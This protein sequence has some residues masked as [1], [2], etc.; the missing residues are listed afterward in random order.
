MSRPRWL[1]VCLALF[2]TFF[3]A[4]LGVSAQAWKFSLDR[5]VSHV[6]VQK[7]GSA[8]IEYWLAFTCDKG[9]HPLD[10]I[11]IGMPNKTY[12]LGTAQAWYVPADGGAEVALARPVQSEMIST[13]IEVHLGKYTIQPGKSGTIHV[14]I[15]VKQMVYPDKDEAYASV[16][17]AP[18]Y[19]D[20][21]NVHGNTF[22]EIA[23]YF[24]VGVTNEQ[25]RYH[26]KKYDYVDK[27]NDRIVFIYQYPNAKGSETHKHGI[28]FPRQYVDTVH[29]APLVWGGS[30]SGG[31]NPFAVLENIIEGLSS[32]GCFGGFIALF[33]AMSALGS[34]QQKRRKMV[35]LPPALSVEGVGI[36][37]GLTAVEAAILLE[38]P[39]NKVL[40]MI[41]FGLLKKKAVVVLEENPLKLE[42]VTPLPQETWHEYE[43]AFLDSVDTNGRLNE[44]VLQKGII[45]LVKSVNDKMKGFSRKETVVYYKSIVDRAWQQVSQETTPEVKSKYLDQGLEWLMMDQKFQDR[46]SETFSSGPVLMPPWWTYYRPWVPHV[47]SHRIGSGAVPL[48]GGGV[49]RSSGGG[50]VTLPTLP[51]AAFAGT[52]VSGIERTAGGIV[53]KLESFTGGVT[54]KTNPLPAS[55]SSSSS[56]RSGGC[57]CA[58]ACACAGCACAC[59]GG[60][61]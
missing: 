49:S 20:S 56:Y 2:L 31:S 40:T 4:I 25:T 28:S 35:Y 47:H 11:D 19:Y 30:S 5:N 59:A 26:D 48:S 16:E 45:A 57:A 50:Q 32:F 38:Q 42:K 17:F 58:C 55:S 15:N 39:L 60:G 36:K 29:K 54:A 3:V 6:I 13:G 9:A 33:I 23:F 21:Q 41:L 22:M 24:P 1:I 8:D 61:R 14:K 52:V 46:A 37:R 7:D 12:D 18:H 43:T 53:S 34:A 51:G 10:I 44:D 27:S